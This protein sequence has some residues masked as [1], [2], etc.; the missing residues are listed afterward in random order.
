M[1]NLSV[2]IAAWGKPKHI[3]EATKGYSNL[4]KVQLLACVIEFK[5]T[6]FNFF[7]YPR[8][9]MKLQKLPVYF[10]AHHYFSKEQ[11]KNKSTVEEKKE[12]RHIHV[13]T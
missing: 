2:F 6:R 5:H 8:E 12:L 10:K 1:F 13:L 4:S 3:K 11:N 9:D 7:K